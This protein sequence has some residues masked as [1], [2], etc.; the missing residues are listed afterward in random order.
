MIDVMLA[1][2]LDAR[3]LHIWA[4]TD[5]CLRSRYGNQVVHGRIIGGRHVHA[6][7]QPTLRLTIEIEALL[8]HR[9]RLDGLYYMGAQRGYLHGTDPAAHAA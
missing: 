7:E 5:A 9:I 8:E 3:D 1:H 2:L 4:S 6:S